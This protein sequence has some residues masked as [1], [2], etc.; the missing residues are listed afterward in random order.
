MTFRRRHGFCD[1]PK[2]VHIT[3]KGI[4]REAVEQ[5]NLWLLGAIIKFVSGF[6][7]DAQDKVIVYSIPSHR[8]C[9]VPLEPSAKAPV[10]F[11]SEVL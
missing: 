1:A 9:I 2:Y 8:V 5:R 11:I 7:C 6:Q 4:W 3:L 10:I